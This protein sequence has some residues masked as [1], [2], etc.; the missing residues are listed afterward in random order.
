M[1]V[2]KNLTGTFYGALDEF[3]L[4]VVQALDRGDAEITIYSKE[5]KGHG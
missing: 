1:L 2:C 4:L 5:K 3:A